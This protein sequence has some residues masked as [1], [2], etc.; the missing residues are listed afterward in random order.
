[1][2]P[3]FFATAER[4]LRFRGGDTAVRVHYLVDVCPTV[5]ALIDIQCQ[6]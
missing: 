2:L 5:F 1:M 6:I 4:L 3:A